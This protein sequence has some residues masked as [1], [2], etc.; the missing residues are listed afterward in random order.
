MRVVTKLA[1]VPRGS[2]AHTPHAKSSSAS[3]SASASADAKSEGGMGMGKSTGRGV[4]HD[5]LAVPD[6][7]PASDP[8]RRNAPPL[9]VDYALLLPKLD[10]PGMQKWANLA[11]QLHL[12]LRL[13][14]LAVRAKLGELLDLGENA[15]AG[16]GVE[17][18]ARVEAG[19][20]EGEV[21]V[22]SDP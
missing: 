19:E 20:S 17:A 7:D 14:K 12:P 3:A 15:G 16:L 6:P 9:H 18:G 2:Y 1:H 13:V 4:G 22:P 11:S 5:A 21:A 8:V 10:P